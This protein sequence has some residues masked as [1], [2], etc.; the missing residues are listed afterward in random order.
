MEKIQI[1]KTGRE[2]GANR[3]RERSLDPNAEQASGQEVPVLHL[4]HTIT[5]QFNLTTFCTIKKT[6]EGA[7]DPA[8]CTRMDNRSVEEGWLKREKL[9]HSDVQTG[10]ITHRG[11][12]R[13]ADRGRN[14]PEV[15]FNPDI[16]ECGGEQPREREIDSIMPSDQST[17]NWACEAVVNVSIEDMTTWM[18]AS[19]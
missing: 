14:W 4:Q 9:R 6:L 18:W 12:R 13:E 15:R 16:L 5:I 3:S 19:S 10:L 11:T 1:K 7:T 17:A 8:G 2:K